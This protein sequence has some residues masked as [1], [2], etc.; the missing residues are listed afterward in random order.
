MLRLDVVVLYGPYFS[1]LTYVYSSAFK[2]VMS[3]T[4]IE[5]FEYAGIFPPLGRDRLDA[6]RGLDLKNPNGELISR[7]LSHYV[8]ETL[9]LFLSRYTLDYH[10]SY[11]IFS[12]VLLQIHFLSLISNSGRL[13]P[14]RRRPCVRRWQHPFV[15][16]SAVT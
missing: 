12:D 6:N 5:S 11:L 2:T 7:T 4:E 15:R 9:L 8:R 3:N 1:F 14:Q 13:P 10:S 16:D